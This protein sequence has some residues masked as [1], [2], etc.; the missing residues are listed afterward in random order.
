MKISDFIFRYT[1]F[2]SSIRDSICRVRIFYTPDA[3]TTAV[4]TDL[5]SKNTGGSV[6]NTVEA[7]IRKLIEAGHIN[8]E[9]R[10]IEHYEDSS[11]Q[12]ATY[13]LVTL[14]HD[15]PNWQHITI[16]RAA[17]LIGCEE[18]E[19]SGRTLEDARLVNQ[20]ERLRIQVDPH[21]DRPYT[22]PPEVI[23]RRNEI[24]RNRVPLTQLR[25]LIQSGANER[26]LHHLIASDLSLIAEIYAKPDDEYLV[27]T[28]FPLDEGRVDFAVFSGRSRMDVTLVEIKGADFPLLSQ[29]GYR[30]LNAKFNEARQ[31]ISA[32]LGY[33]YRE[34]ARF[35]EQMHKIRS[36]AELGKDVHHVYRGPKYELMV[37]PEKDVNV[38]YVVIGGRTGDDLAESKIRHDFEVSFNPQIRLESWDTW[39]RKLQRH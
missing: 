32:R 10:V 24:S 4:L 35:R 9:T 19:I 39:T 29:T 27:F 13:A 17:Q 25:S 18:S 38:H 33:I 7:L 34:Y 8:G 36:D 15:L 5:G 31:Q 21:L 6:A 37:D 2:R 14:Q 12:G 16:D 23:N 22:E 1:P 20:I 30:N 3:G 11:F 28:E 26:D